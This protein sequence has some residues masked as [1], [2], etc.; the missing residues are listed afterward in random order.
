MANNNEP[1]LVELRKISAWADTQRKMTKWSLIAAAVLVPAL[2]GFAVLM[3]QFGKTRPERAASEETADWHDV[4]Q[5]VRRGDFG[6]A[7]RIGEKLLQKTPQY[8]EAHRRL[9]G[10]YLAAGHLAQARTHYAEAFRLFP[11]EENE[12]LL[13]AIDRRI[14]AGKPQ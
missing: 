11:S 13:L 3:E 12:K 6:K 2:V 4:D 14:K 8:P 5:S 10:T 7:I 9:A 1:I